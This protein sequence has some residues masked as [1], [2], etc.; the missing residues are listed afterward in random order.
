MSGW[1]WW[2]VAAVAFS[3]V[4]MVTA[5]LFVVPFAAGAL[6]AAA[7][8]LVG[9]GAGI[10]VAL[11][12]VGS[13]A[14]FTVTRPIARR[15][16]SSPPAIRTGTAALIGRSATALE[17]VTGEAGSVK[18]DGEVWTA[19]AYDEDVV[20]PAGAHVQVIEIRG[21]TALVVDGEEL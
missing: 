8:D 9:A 5:T 17:E 2:V 19:R 18:L 7:A 3:V 6:L 20:I 12:L 13:G 16:R 4:E 21:A 11:F 15:H 1:V 14:A 10:Q